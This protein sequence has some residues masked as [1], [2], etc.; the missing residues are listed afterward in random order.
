MEYTNE[1]LET[2]KEAKDAMDILFARLIEAD[3]GFFPSKSG[4]PWEVMLKIN[5]VINKAEDK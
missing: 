2:L 3:R 5:D 1:I 4:I